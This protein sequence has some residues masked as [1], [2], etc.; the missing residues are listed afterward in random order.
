[1]TRTKKS[2]NRRDALKVLGAAGTG[3]VTA[4]LLP[5]KWD[6]P[7]MQM[8]V[9]PVHAQS[10][11]CNVVLEYVREGVCQQF[12]GLAC[13][14][15]NHVAQFSYTPVDLTP[16]QVSA[17]VCGASISCGMLAGVPGTVY[18]LVNRADLNCWGT[19]RITIT[20][21]GGCTGVWELSP[22][23][24]QLGEPGSFVP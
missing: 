4:T 7:T 6:K 2:L 14:N 12:P 23:S 19:R 11:L 9:L 21:V 18:V 20:F 24:Q 13:G 17:I 8:G 1:M 5:G 10:S 3:L 22:P 16:F 15:F